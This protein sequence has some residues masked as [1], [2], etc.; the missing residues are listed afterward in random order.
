M[1][2]A[3][4]MRKNDVITREDAFN[5]LTEYYHHK[6]TLQHLALRDALNRVPPAAKSSCYAKWIRG[7]IEKV[8][9]AWRCSKCGKIVYEKSNYCPECGRYMKGEQDE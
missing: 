1:Y 4:F 3:G 9:M 2:G 5:T 6:T 8:N 7:D